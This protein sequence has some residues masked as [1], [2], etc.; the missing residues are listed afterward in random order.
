MNLWCDTAGAGPDLVLLH[1]WGMNAAVWKPLLPGLQERFRVTLIEL[2]GHGESPPVLGGLDDWVR[3]CLRVAPPRAAW[4]GWS[5]GGLL[6]LRAAL[7]A[8]QRIGRLCLVTATPSFVQ[9]EGWAGAMP[10]S[11]FEQFSAALIEDPAA[12]LRRF[13]ALQVK[14]SEDARVL[15]RTLDSALAQRRHADPEGLQQG[16]R[17]LLEGDLRA[18]L[19]QL[20]MPTSWLF[21]GR[22]TL[23]PVQVAE[24]IRGRLAGA[25]VE[26]I[27]SAGHAPFLSH[28]YRALQWLEADCAH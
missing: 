2:P 25:R 1:G 13:L 4:V 22:D 6:A 24:E 28:P 8:P 15:L 7:L 14:G 20:E 9:R 3:A 27:E 5:L 16:L 12:T 10:Q 21:G 18:E 26:I 11:V 19:D 17:L 23:V